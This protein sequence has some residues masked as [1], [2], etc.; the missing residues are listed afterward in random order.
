MFQASQIGKKRSA[1]TQ[2][3]AILNEVFIT[4]TNDTYSLVGIEKH[5]AKNIYVYQFCLSEK[6]AERKILGIIPGNSIRCQFKH[7][8][9]CEDACEFVKSL[10]EML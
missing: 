7:L 2:A 9:S 4:P 10:L 5:G 1:S 8:I 6:E 3:S